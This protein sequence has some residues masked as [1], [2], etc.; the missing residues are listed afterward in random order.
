MKIGILTFSSTNDNYGQLFQG[1]A[2]QKYL[3]LQGHDAYIIRYRYQPARPL[4][5]KIIKVA[6]VYPLIEW[7]MN[8]KKRQWLL[9][10]VKKNEKRD[11]ETFRKQ[12][13]RQSVVSYSRLDELKR[14]PPLA[15]CYIAG[16]DQIWSSLSRKK[17]YS[18]YFLPFGPDTI[19]RVAYAA[20]FGMTH[21]PEAFRPRLKRELKRFDHISV[22]EADGI[23]ICEE[24]GY[25]AQQVL[26]PTFLLPVSVYMS[27]VDKLPQFSGEYAYLYILN[28]LTA[29]EIKW[30]A[31]ASVLQEKAWQPV[32][33]ISS[34]YLPA[35]ELFDVDNYYYATPQEWLT[36]IFYSQLVI[37]TSFHGVVFSLLFHKNFIFFPLK[38]KFSIGNNRVYDL[39]DKVGLS[40][41]I[42]E[43]ATSI[44]EAI[45]IPVSWP[46]V[47][48]RL[49]P[50]KAQSISYL[51]QALK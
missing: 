17:E 11:F 25:K 21:Y 30:E 5:R 18:V 16:S 40:A 50:F 42:I 48:D 41:K 39:L 28:V 3:Q 35:R 24:V 7:I 22:R 4:L 38:N 13:F 33:T 20:S 2:L 1:Y 37:T 31:L 32:F 46:S 27:F 49:Q 29:S 14:H 51:E 44:R 9:L 10:L 12:Y 23:R 26:D 8:Y 45:H 15:G 19:R 43:D 36:H 6:L 34:G 47:D